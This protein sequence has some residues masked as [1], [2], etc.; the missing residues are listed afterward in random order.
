MEREGSGYDRMYEVLLASGKKP[1]VVSENN[2]RVVVTVKKHIARQE[3][4]DFMVKAHQTFYPTQKE[5]ITLGLIAQHQAL[6]AIEL[7]DLLELK[8]ADDLRPWLGRLRGWGLV[9]KRGHTKATE[10]LVDPH[11]LRKLAFEG[12]TTL[13]GIEKHRLRAL[14]LQDFAIYGDVSIG[15]LHQRIG[16]EIPRR[17]IQRE[18]VDLATSE[19]IVAVGS[20]RGRKYRIAPNEAE[21]T[22]SGTIPSG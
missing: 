8:N 12:T 22:G 15:D 7:V 21:S 20:G 4:V 19:Q 17:R 18:L 11:V 13:K 1:P 9:G 3:V 14:I 16:V 6:T 2:D 5:L 10:Y